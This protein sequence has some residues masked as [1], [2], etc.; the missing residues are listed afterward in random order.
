[1]RLTPRGKAEG[2]RTGMHRLCPRML[3]SW[4]AV[5]NI[6]RIT[7]TTGTVRPPSAGATGSVRDVRHSGS[8]THRGQLKVTS[9]AREPPLMPSFLS[10][11]QTKRGVG[12][13]RVD[14]HPIQRVRLLHALHRSSE[15]VGR[16]GARLGE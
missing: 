7:L 11:S 6:V 10:R 15:R 9:A 8:A 13:D 3:G 14:H 1:M 2:Q 16:P 12:I 4:S 5:P